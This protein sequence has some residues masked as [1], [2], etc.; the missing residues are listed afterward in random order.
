MTT[1]LRLLGFLRPYRVAVLVTALAAA[2]LMAC[3]L[4]LPYLTGRVID[5]V[6]AEGRRDALTPLL[7]AVVLVVLVRFVLGVVRRV[8]AGRVS[9]AVE[10]DMRD[11][12]FGHAQRLSFAFFDRMPV[13]QLMSRATSDLQTVRFFLGYGLVFLFMNAFTLVLATTILLVIDAR[14][15]LVSLLVGP[16]LIAVAVRYSRRTA[17]VRVDV[18]QKLGEVTQAA[19]ESI[20]GVRVV[21]AFGR[22]RERTD[23]FGA[24]ARRAFDR[25][26]DATRLESF[27]QP[28]MGF[29]PVVGLAVVLL[30]GGSLVIDGD[31]TLGQ[32]VQFYLYL[33]LLMG[34]FRML[35]N[36]VGQAQRAVAGGQRI[37]EITDAV[38]DVQEAPGATPLPDG[39]GAIRFEGVRFAY[40]EGRPVLDGVDLDIAAGTTVALIGPTGSGKTTL[41]ELIPRYYDPAE[42]RVLVD[43]ADVRTVRL[44]DLRRAIG[45]VSQEPFLFSASVRDNIAYGRPDA[46]DEE[47]RA[48]ARRARA[49]AF[50]EALPQGYDTLIGERGLMLSGGQ[51]QRLAIARAVITD[52]RILVLDEATASVDA[53]TEREIQ[54]A[55]RDVMRGRTTLIIAHRLSTIRLADELVVLDGGRVVARG[56]HE[57]LYAESALYREIHDGGLARPDLVL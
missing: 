3:T 46:S 44:Q 30:Y 28:A 51:R 16:A 19:E 17:P 21:K 1:L 33:T 23:R 5:D 42:G 55:L 26:M 22:E 24:T 37:F 41:T 45:V 4:T 10:Y 49:D 12:V 40:A 27:Y 52:P 11:V 9:L 56:R 32:F 54:D 39:G 38:P 15:A 18:Q 35:G 2:G 53:S 31:L 13:G 25:S 14:L 50:I 34:P 7:S 48:A 36:L 20:V 29:L 6:L 8:L 43:G 47:V 57:E